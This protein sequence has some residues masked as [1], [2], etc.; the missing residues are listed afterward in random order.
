MKETNDML[1]DRYVR[2]IMGT[3][4][5][6]DIT[7]DTITQL[8]A[9]Y[10]TTPALQ[11]DY[12][13]CGPRQFYEAH[14][15]PLNHSMTINQLLTTTLELL[16]APAD[17]R[18]AIRDAS[19]L[20]WYLLDDAARSH[21]IAQVRG[22]YNLASPMH[23]PAQPVGQK[24]PNEWV[25]FATYSAALL[26]HGYVGDVT[27]CDVRKILGD[28]IVVPK[29]NFTSPAKLANYNTVRLDLDVE[30][31]F[32]TMKQLFEKVRAHFPR[33]EIPSICWGLLDKQTKTTCASQVVN[34]KYCA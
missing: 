6:V 7:T 3:Q 12:P 14:T 13:P 2:G 31:K 32:I 28:T 26:G 34:S 8:T 27:V 16:Q 11:P 1:F 20:C 18:S 19:C 33:K 21:C 15:A 17:S 9:D 25:L 10:V 4:Q 23:V 29:P 22:K 30:G 5:V 24:K